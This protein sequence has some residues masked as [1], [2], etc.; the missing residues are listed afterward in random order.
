MT[1]QGTPVKIEGKFEK[2]P[3]EILDYDVD[4]TEW[5]EGRQDTPASHVVIVPSGI[6]KVSDALT[7]MTVKV[8]LGGGLAG[9]KYKIT[10]RLTTAAGLVKEADFEL[11]VKEV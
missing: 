1:T 11:R 2:Q 8:V 10:V 9:E 6:T 4:Y 7:G 3:A 5:F